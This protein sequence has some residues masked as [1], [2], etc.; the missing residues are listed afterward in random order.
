LATADGTDG[1]PDQA[2]YDRILGTA[3]VPNIPRT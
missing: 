1:Y 3:A 2:P